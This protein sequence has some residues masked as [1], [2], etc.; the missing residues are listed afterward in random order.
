MSGVSV[1]L[2]RARIGLWSAPGSQLSIPHLTGMAI[3]RA[4]AGTSVQFV[5]DTYPTGFRGESSSRSYAM[6]ARYMNG[7]QAQVLALLALFDVAHAAPDSR[8]ILRT[9]FGQVP[10]LDG[11]EAVQVFGVTPTPAMGLY[12][13]VA[14]T[15]LVVESSIA[16]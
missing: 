6:T 11:T 2:D 5:G 12:W 9:H 3:T 4:Y 14:F 15:A 16:V 13:D 8:L 7:E 1:V 10:G